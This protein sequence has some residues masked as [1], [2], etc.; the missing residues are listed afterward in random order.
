MIESTS[1]FNEMF[2]KLGR[3]ICFPP[4]GFFWP[5]WDKQICTVITEISTDNIN[6]YCDNTKLH[7]LGLI[8]LLSGSQTF[9]HVYYYTSYIQRLKER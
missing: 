3:H 2:P 8:A 5:K 7:C 1:H 4:E 6:V 9:F